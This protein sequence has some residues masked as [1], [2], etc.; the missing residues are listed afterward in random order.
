M[1]ESGR[2]ARLRGVWGNPWGF[3]SPSRHQGTA[4][5]ADL[6]SEFHI[7]RGC[8]AH[9]N[10]S[11]KAHTIRTQIRA[12]EKEG[13]GASSLGGGPGRGLEMTGHAAP[14]AE[15]PRLAEIL[16]ALSLV[17]DLAR[18]EPP[19]E[20]MRASLLATRLAARMSAARDD[21]ADV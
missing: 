13:M 2:R 1:A 9:A 21:V 20:A 4:R 11:N 12:V 7:R 19:G 3:K 14:L 18:G 6:A 5:Q 10:F 16:A 15:R 17:T 8:Q